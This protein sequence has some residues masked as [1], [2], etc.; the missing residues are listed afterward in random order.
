VQNAYAEGDERGPIPDGWG[1]LLTPDREVL[2]HLEWDRG[3]EQPRR[4]RAKLGAYAGY[5]N[6]RP[7]AGANQ[8]LFVA[9]TEQRERQILGLLRDPADSDRESCRFWTST[10][11]FIATVG[12]LGAAWA[13]NGSRR[14]ALLDMAG[15]ARSERQV[16]ASV[17]KPSWWLRRPGAGAGS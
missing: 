3:T 17:G 5:F 2:L 8:I 15:V 4:L 12:P 14:V 16:E 10:T 11:A 7:A 9:P 1:R 6:D 13:G